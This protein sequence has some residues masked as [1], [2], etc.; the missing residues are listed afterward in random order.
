MKVADVQP[1][2]ACTS[3][4]KPLLVHIGAQIE[5]TPDMHG[6][7]LSVLPFLVPYLASKITSAQDTRHGHLSEDKI[8]VVKRDPVTSTIVHDEF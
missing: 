5:W 1:D 7:S 4:L 6:L 3:V 2:F 8:G